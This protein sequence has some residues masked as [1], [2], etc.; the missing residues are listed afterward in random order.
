MYGETGALEIEITNV[1]VINDKGNTH[2]LR[3]NFARGSYQQ[4]YRRQLYASSRKDYKRISKWNSSP[5]RNDALRR[6]YCD[7]E[8]LKKLRGI[9]C[10]YDESSSLWLIHKHSRYQYQIAIIISGYLVKN[11]SNDAH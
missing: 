4:Q 2:A 1:E 3:P 10:L 11:M 9:V 8:A 7:V 5:F 6:V